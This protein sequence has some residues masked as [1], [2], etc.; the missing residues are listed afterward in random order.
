MET[1]VTVEDVRWI[2]QKLLTLEAAHRNLAKAFQSH[3]PWDQERRVA[4]EWAAEPGVPELVAA[5]CRDAA[6]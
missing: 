1:T 4:T 3:G 2:L 5:L 6:R